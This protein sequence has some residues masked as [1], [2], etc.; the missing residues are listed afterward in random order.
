MQILEAGK[1]VSWEM[2]A[3][4]IRNWLQKKDPT[5]FEKISQTTINGW[6]DRSGPQ[7]KW[8]DN[9]LWLA[10]KGN[11]QGHPNGGHRGALVSESATIEGTVLNIKI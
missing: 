3:S 5:V 4:A 8:S 1:A 7:P 10:E 11:Q 6:I 2:S 9:T